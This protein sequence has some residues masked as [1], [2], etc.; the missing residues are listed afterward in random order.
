MRPPYL[1]VQEIFCC[2]IVDDRIYS[3]MKNEKSST[4]LE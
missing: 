4:I 3:L 2:A 1:R